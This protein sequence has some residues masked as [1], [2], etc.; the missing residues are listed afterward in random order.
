MSSERRHFAAITFVALSLVCL[1]LRA[2]AQP[3]LAAHYSWEVH[4]GVDRAEIGASFPTSLGG[5]VGSTAL[6]L[7]VNVDLAQWHATPSN[8]PHSR[9]T[10][11]GITPQLRLLLPDAERVQPYVDL[12]VG[13][14]WLD[15]HDIDGHHLG[16]SFQFGDYIGLGARF[17]EGRRAAMSLRVFHESNGGTNKS[18]SGLT[19]VG[20][21]I[22][23]ALP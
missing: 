6:N 11:V 9:L 7:A 3:T 21:R 16:Q 17:G 20:I 1:A 15:G 12:G 22:E 18:N 13:P 2:Q 23:Y 8:E 4:G 5:R 19:T 10:D 14:H